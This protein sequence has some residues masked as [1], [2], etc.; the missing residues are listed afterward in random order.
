MPTM[1]AA[2]GPSGVAF[3]THHIVAALHS[4]KVSVAQPNIRQKSRL[5][6]ERFSL[7]TRSGMRAIRS[8]R[9][10]MPSHPVES[11]ATDSS[12][13]SILCFVE[14]C[15]LIVQ[16]YETFHKKQLLLRS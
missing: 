1:P 8:V 11:N 9:P 5:E 6:S 2:R 16:I 7:I 14:F 3:H 4:I 10:V 12:T 15:F 13:R